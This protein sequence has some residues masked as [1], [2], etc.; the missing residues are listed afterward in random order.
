MLCAMSLAD[1]GSTTAAETGGPTTR[2]R[3]GRIVLAASALLV[4]VAALVIY[5][6]TRPP[7]QKSLQA[8][9]LPLAAQAKVGTSFMDCSKVNGLAYFDHWPCQTFVLVHS[10][11]FGTA[12]ALDSA[13]QARLGAAGW[14]Y[15]ARGPIPV[16]YDALG[17]ANVPSS[18]SWTG[19][20]NSACAVILTDTAGA[21]LEAEAI[22]RPYDPYNQ[23][24][25]LIAFYR[26]ARGADRAETLWCA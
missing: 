13:E 4:A 22:L 1:P 17:S 15:S 7:D 16:D 12:Q 26:V 20:G 5:L 9:V 2:R 21:A 3:T 24:Q 8:S 23:P 25:G 6:A 10:S 11:H 19:P 18:A 14:H